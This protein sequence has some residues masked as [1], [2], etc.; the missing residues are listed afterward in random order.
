M[1][2]VLHTE[3]SNAWGGQENRSLLESK[4]LIK[5]GHRAIIL[6]QPGSGLEKYASEAGIPVAVVKMRSSYDPVAVNFIRRLIQR[7]GIDVV[8]THSS[9]DSWLA[10]IGS[11]LSLK[12]P[13]FVRTRHL[14]IGIK[15]SLTYTLLPHRIVTVS[16]YVRQLFLAR[17]LPAD[18]VVTIPSGIDT[19]KFDPA[20]CETSLRR[21]L[22][23]SASVPVVV[24]IAIL[25]FDKGHYYFVHAAKEVL[26]MVPEVKFLIV[27]DGPQKENIMRYIN[28]LNINNNVLMLGLRRDIPKVL[29]TADLYVIPSIQ[30]GMGQSTMEAMAMGV[31]VIASSVGGLPELVVDN[32]TGLL[33]PPG[34]ISALARAIEELLSDK[35]KAGRLSDV[36][37]K[38]ILRNYTIEKTVDRTL[39][40]YAEI[41][42]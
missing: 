4:E 36:A 18:K 22:G 8:N 2:T 16:E 28:E 7:E 9:K 31:P 5:R 32:K 6:C 27:G 19:E 24:M 3:S 23:I 30:E 14:A 21:E 17:G 38:S 11:W 15:K 25:R 40:L 10:S 29:S 39:E 1:F 35:E 33:V 12:K 34:D 26:K 20:R 42:Q 37:R 41:L 13:A